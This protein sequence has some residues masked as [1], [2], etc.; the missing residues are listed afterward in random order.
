[1]KA[2]QVGLE[3]DAKRIAQEKLRLE[4]DA[5]RAINKRRRKESRRAHRRLDQEVP[6]KEEPEQPKKPVKKI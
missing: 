4:Q 5:I 1:M 3:A 2:T 6:K